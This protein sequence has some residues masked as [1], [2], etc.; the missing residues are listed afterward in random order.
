MQA[1]DRKNR[2]AVSMII[3]DDFTDEKWERLVHSVEDYVDCIYVNYNGTEGK[4]PKYLPKI[5]VI[6]EH[7][8]W[9]KDFGKARNQALSLIPMDLYT[10]WLWIDLDDEAVNFDQLDDLL[11]NLHKSTQA[12]MLRYDYATDPLTG[13]ASA[14]QDRERIFRTD[15]SGRWIYPIHELY[16]MPAGVQIAKRTGPLD[17]SITHHKQDGFTDGLD[18]GTRERNKEI[19]VE[20]LK[21]DPYDLRLRFYLANEFYAQAALALADENTPH[22]EAHAYC[23]LAINAYSVYLE[24]DPPPD[25]A[26]IATHQIAEIHRMKGEFFEAIEA[27]MQATMIHSHWPDAWLGIAQSYMNIG[28]W[29]KALF[30]AEIC[31]KIA[32][33]PETP[34]LREPLNLE[35]LPKSIMATCF[36]QKAEY[37]KA[38]ELYEELA[39]VSKSEELDEKIEGLKNLI[40]FL[41]NDITPLNTLR[42]DNY[43]A[44][45][46]KSIA[47]FC[48]PSLE[49]WSSKTMNETG[50]GGTETA[51][52]EVA[53]RF[54]EDGW[55]VAIFASPTDD[56]NGTVF[57]GIEW[58]E[59]MDI[60]LTEPWNTLVSVRTPELFD[61]NFNAKKKILWL[62]DVNNG[63]D[64]FTDEDGNNR[65]DKI[66]L[67]VP[68]S[69]WHMNHL[70]KL[71]GIPL[72]KMHPARN[73]I[74]IERFENKDIE[75]N[76]YKFIWSSSPDRGLDI[77]LEMWPEIVGLVPDAELHIFYG[78]DNYD[79]VMEMTD[80][81]FMR[82]FK[83]K[84]LKLLESLKNENI[85]WRGRVDQETLANEFLSAGYWPYTGEF[86]E[87]NCLSVVEAQAGG[88]L[89]IISNIGAAPENLS[90]VGVKIDGFAKNFDYR[91]SFIEELEA[92]ILRS[93]EQKFFD[94]CAMYKFA[95]T[96]SWDEQFKT[97][98]VF[99]AV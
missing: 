61:S 36:E 32:S 74:N 75:R 28:D 15:L 35:Y 71:Y 27:E 66:D 62:H 40:E 76:P 68:V 34:I 23:D 38:L 45:E 55:R 95:K 64:A 9:E 73:G 96:Q 70:H 54:A 43:G 79:K 89:P 60:D 63:P 6:W 25:E 5:P 81:P 86:L 26:Y 90:D 85:H 77:V 52:C 1:I 3:G 49:K 12:V 14:V 78:W 57:D 97:W 56:V 13:K 37:K 69:D 29:D 67:I 46:E 51:V 91:K 92:L 84:I 72:E 16:R 33:E 93:R 99:T 30:H 7:F 87:T 80:N 19:I 21:E 20:A 39:T 8:A 22:G 2:V 10:H 18:D 31:T 65:W 17:P 48:R 53:K 83:V 98:K 11:S 59:S 44:N 94:H 42:E 4:F 47:F 58:Y 82:K 41:E 24:L 88:C 50:I